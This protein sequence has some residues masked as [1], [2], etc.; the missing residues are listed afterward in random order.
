MRSLLTGS[1]ARDLREDP[2]FF[3]VTSVQ[4]ADRIGGKSRRFDDLRADVDIS[5]S[6]VFVFGMLVA[7]K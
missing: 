3:K 5:A 6:E 2:E 1:V 4:I 7:D